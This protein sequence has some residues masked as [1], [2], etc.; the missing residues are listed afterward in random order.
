MHLGLRAHLLPASQLRS[1]DELTA[2]LDLRHGDA[3]AKRSAFWTMLL[4]S[5]V[6]ASAG[7]LADSTATVIGAMIIAP[8]STPIMGVALGIVTRSRNR[9]LRIALGGAGLVVLVGY[10]FT[11][12]LPHSYN[13]LANSQIAGRTSP[14]LLDLVAAMATGLAGAVALSRRDVAAVLPGVAIAISLV[15]PLAVVGVCLGQGDGGLA[16]GALLLFVSNLLALVLCGTLVFAGLGYSADRREG[17]GVVSRRSY[18]ALVALVLVVALPLAANT[19]FQYLLNVWT[20]RVQET[21]EEWVEETPH[22]AV[23]D[24]QI[25][26]TEIHVDV[27]APEGLPAVSDL[28]D[29]LAE[30]LPDG[31]RIVVNH[32]QGERIDAGAVGD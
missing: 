30:E 13:L 20:A 10:L 27:R 5:A 8:L 17:A 22:A 6:I 4:L 2:E 28:M 9:A 21:A 24:V 1:L 15:P 7:V 11:L 25:V 16:L 3:I 26:S 31:I 32:V 29:R 12:A 14:G 23:T 18:V 19:A